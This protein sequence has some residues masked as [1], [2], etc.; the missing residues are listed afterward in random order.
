MPPE[1]VDRSQSALASN[2]RSARETRIDSD[3]TLNDADLRASERLKFALAAARVGVWEWDIQADQVFWSAEC[4]EILHVSAFGG[5]F[6]DFQKLVHADDRQ[7]IN[8][9]I[10]KAIDHRTQFAAEV[11]V[12]RGDGQIRWIASYGRCEYERDG[13]PKRLV[14]TAQDITDRK[15]T[16]NDL[17]ASE[18]RLRATLDCMLDGCQIL[19]SDLRYVYLNANAQRHSG[20]RQEDLIGKRI[21]EVYPGIEG[22]PLY[23]AIQECIAEKAAREIE[24]RFAFPDGSIGDFEFNIVPASEG[25]IIL[26]CDITER[27]HAEAELRASERRFREGEERYRLALDAA[28]MGTWQFDY[29]TERVWMDAACQGHNGLAESSMKP[30]DVFRWFHPQDLQQLIADA[31]IAHNSVD[32][33][34]SFSSEYRILHSN[35]AYHWISLAARFQF[36]VIEGKRTP[37]QIHGTTQDVTNRKRTEIVVQR[38]T[39]VLEQIARGLPLNAILEEVVELV[40]DQFPGSCCSISLTE[41]RLNQLRFAAGKK[42]PSTYA[43]AAQVIPIGPNMG[44]CGTSAFLAEPIIVADIAND[45]LAA[46]FREIALQQNLRSC[47]SVPILRSAAV[48]SV[49][50]PGLVL[51]TFAVYWTKPFCPCSEHKEIIESAVHLARL[52]IERENSFEAIRE[53][54]A[55]YT[56]ISEITRSVTFAL[57]VKPDGSAIIDWARPRYGLVSGYTEEE[58][59]RIGWEPL[60]LPEDR[61]RITQMFRQILGGVPRREECRMLTKAGAVLHVLVQGKLYSTD[62]ISGEKLI[63]GGL[64]DITE[65]KS[66][67][68]A[69]RE[70]EERFELAL[71][72]ANDGLWDWNIQTGRFFVSPRWKSMLGYEGAELADAFETWLDLMHPDDRAAAQTQLRDFLNGTFDQYESEFRMRHKSGAYVDVLSRAFVLRDSQGCPSR[73]VGTHQDITDRKAA[74]EELRASRQR[75]KTLSKQLITTRESELRH[76]ARELHDEVGQG[77]TLMKMNLR[78]IQKQADDNIR[79][80]LEENI[81]MIERTVEQVRSLSLNMRPPHLDDLGLVATLHWYLKQQSK[82]AG[83]QESISVIP[84]DLCVPTELATVCFRITQEAVTNAIRHAAPSRIEIE[85]RKI[86]EVFALTIRD[87]GIGFDVGIAR[88]KALEGSSLGLISMEER[89]SLAGGRMEIVSAPQRGTLIRVQFLQSHS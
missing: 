27:K 84:P 1:R 73:M 13:A 8:E 83:F 50:Q 14:G 18:S 66:V 51:G 9:A 61:S 55:R 22:T 25:V 16:E 89:A 32:G 53:S 45:P 88:Q 42:L 75:L 70:S 67:E 60:I 4:Y 52:A 56:A 86:G 26:S 20:A 80:R 33:D 79:V 17:S 35:G 74:D 43:Q 69:L 2:E 81:S 54:E 85:L 7:C 38:Q 30:D 34:G 39:A 24:S 47:W 62:A 36:A 64:L 72:G 44:S 31:T 11:R 41:P 65:L 57:R 10:S 19:D 58:F 77:L 78:H 71:R 63:I 15:V 46:A 5:T 68:L 12:I 21:E 82:N 76:L 6:A 59:R 40:E 87:D 3:H 29:L 23:V 48:E 28:A 37:V 49:D